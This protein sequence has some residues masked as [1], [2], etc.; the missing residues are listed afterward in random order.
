MYAAVEEKLY[1]NRYRVDHE[2]P[3]IGIINP[4][5]C[6]D[7]CQTKECATVCPA[8]CYRVQDNGAVVL[9]T[10]GCLECGSCRL[11]CASHGNIEWFYPRGGYGIA[12]K[13]G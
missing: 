9:D 6:R 5:Y 7:Q 1:Q 2:R 3:H 4:G 10:D 11:L 8:G 13:F 12:Y